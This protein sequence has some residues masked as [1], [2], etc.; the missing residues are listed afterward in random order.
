MRSQS[1]RDK[2]PEQW[3]RTGAVD[4]LEASHVLSAVGPEAVALYALVV[5]PLNIALAAVEEPFVHPIGWNFLQYNRP[6][7]IK[8]DKT[9]S[10]L[11]E[12]MVAHTSII[13]RRNGRWPGHILLLLWR[14]QTVFLL[15]EAVNKFARRIVVHLLLR[16]ARLL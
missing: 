14:V 12:N 11:V 10:H 3:T 5:K 2:L 7:H 8:S 6:K 15:Q 13:T 16:D 1:I 4:E 9:V